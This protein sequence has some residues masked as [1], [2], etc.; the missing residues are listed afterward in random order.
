MS[1]DTEIATGAVT[2]SSIS[3]LYRYISLT[4]PE[5]SPESGSRAVIQMHW[6]RLIALRDRYE[7]AASLLG[8]EPPPWVQFTDEELLVAYLERYQRE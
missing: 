5:T 8:V 2:L 7:D 1:T 6:V 4:S 3:E